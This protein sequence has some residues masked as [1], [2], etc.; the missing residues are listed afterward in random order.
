MNGVVRM[1][2]RGRRISAG[3]FEPGKI[4]PEENC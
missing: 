2:M 4:L 1:E 3:R